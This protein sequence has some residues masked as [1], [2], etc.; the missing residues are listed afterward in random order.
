MT[1]SVLVSL[2]RETARALLRQLMSDISEDCWCAGW[3]VGT[4][5]DL[6]RL[7]GQGGGA[8]GQGS[9]S[10]EQAVTLLQLAAALQE[11][12]TYDDWVPLDQWRE[13]LTPPA[14]DAAP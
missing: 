12:P 5:H 7:A 11:W 3:L 4:E 2:P 13:S 1:G 10:A 8:W 14:M 6:W 9:V